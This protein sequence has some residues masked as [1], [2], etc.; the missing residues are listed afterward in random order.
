MLRPHV[1]DD[2]FTGIRVAG[3]FDD[4]VPVLP[5]GDQDG[6]AGRRPPSQ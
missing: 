2:A 5:A 4:L 1:D 6:F 3:G